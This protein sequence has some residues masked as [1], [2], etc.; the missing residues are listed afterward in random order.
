MQSNDVVGARL[1][2]PGWFARRFRDADLIGFALKALRIALF[3]AALLGVWQ[4]VY[5]LEIWKPYSLPSPEAVWLQLRHRQRHPLGSDPA[6]DDANVH[7]V[8]V[9]ARGWVHDRHAVRRQQVH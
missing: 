9:V 4:L 3:Y 8:H 5:E 2:A 1:A 7:R 6:D